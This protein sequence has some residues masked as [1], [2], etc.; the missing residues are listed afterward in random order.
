MNTYLFI[1]GI[2]FFLL[3]I[4]HS[5]I[6]EYLIFKDKRNK[7]LEQVTNGVLVRMAILK[8]LI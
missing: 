5:L 8:K 4:A 3:G 1:A 7:V 6:G 2:L